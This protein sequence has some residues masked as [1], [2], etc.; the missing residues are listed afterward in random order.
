M[1]RKTISTKFAT[2]SLIVSIVII[3]IGYLVLNEYK[4][5]IDNEVYLNTQKELLSTYNEYL[6]S[7]KDIGITNAFS[8]AND[9][10]IKESLLTN[11]RSL[12]IKSLSNINTTLK[13]GTAFKNVKVHIHTNNNKSYLRNW[14]VDKFGDDLSS[15]RESVVKTNKMQQPVNGFEIGKAGLS[16]RSVVP[17]IDN[18]QH[19]GSL[20]FIQGLN[21]VAKAFD[22]SDEGFLLLM[23]MEHKVVDPKSENI[24][25]ND[26]IISQKFQNKIFL[27]DLSTIKISKIL[28]EKIVITD[29][30]FYTYTEVKDFNGKKLGIVILARSFDKVHLALD[31]TEY[32]IYLAMI[33]LVLAILLNLVATIVN[34][35]KIVLN[36]IKKLND[37]INN[38]IVDHNATQIEVLNNDEIGDVVSKFNEYLE[39][40]DRGIKQDQIVIDEAKSVISRANSGL[41]N[42]NIKSKAQSSGVQDLAIEINELVNGMRKNLDML[43]KVLVAFSNAK[44]DYEVNA[45]EGI[46][47]E[48]ASIMS[49]AKNTGVTISSIIAIVDVSTKRLLE[50]S[51][52]LSDSSS[53]LS[54]SSNKQAAGLEEASAAI[55][56][57]LSSIQ[58]SS[59]NTNEMA[60]LAKEVTT[61]S[62][63]GEVLANQTSTAMEEITE[64]VTAINEAI[65]VI[66]QIAF[67]TNILS[68]NAA[69]EAATAGEAGKGF[70]VV[71]QEVRNL[72]SRSAEAANEIKSLVG[73]AA[74]KTKEGQEISRN[75]I[76]GYNHLNENINST[77]N[78]I[79]DVASSA[80][81]QQVSMVQISDTVNQLDRVTQEN[82]NVAG[83]IN[84]MANENEELAKQLGVAITRT[85]FLESSKKGAC[86][87]DM[88]FDFGS[89]KADHINFK[90]ASFLQC[91]KGNH[92]KVVNHHSCK[93]G[94][95]IDGM[96]DTDFTN[97]S[98]WSTLKDAHQNV[99]TLTQDVTELY[100]TDKSNEDIFKV[101]KG[102]EDNIE[103]VFS[104]LDRLR[105]DKCSKRDS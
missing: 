67:Q 93:L 7:K 9:G 87:M 36:P 70:A 90:N 40:I 15:F 2:V 54:D 50:S 35:K 58:E 94:K 31:K 38:V 20:E 86:D 43:S 103:V 63:E 104:S 13:N 96:N 45:I 65:T 99:H 62:K 28:N 75:M 101:T 46:T 22:K 85:T 80:K 57:I 32:L 30:F 81:E 51:K 71:A 11:N 89:L 88:M 95:W 26:Y 25:Q 59:N 19:L 47:G 48:I 16:L 79:N 17:I 3:L 5:T 44:F 6:N 34:V 21:S 69:V 100:A 23:D 55:E 52:G 12:A 98:H 10:L 76:E 73:K 1:K 83:A 84:V 64:Q 24:F 14:K 56:E 74:S 39:S 102:V 82:A 72:A 97:S 27:S 92:F 77:I 105:E 53:A 68:L 42:T 61:S 41:L 49:G 18:G 60:N 29:K 66:D 37:S 78:I 91:E 8:I 4:K 33:I